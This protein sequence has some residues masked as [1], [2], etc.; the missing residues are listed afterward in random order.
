MYCY[1][2]GK[3][4]KNWLLGRGFTVTNQTDVMKWNNISQKTT[5]RRS[6]LDTSMNPT[7]SVTLPSH[8]CYGELEHKLLSYSI[9]GINTASV[10]PSLEDCLLRVSGISL[11]EGSNGLT[12][13][14]F[15]L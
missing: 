2:G 13:S 11:D 4:Q 5:L 6:G 9:Q 7:R 3:N 1:L 15:R 12:L 10:R 14:E 8:E